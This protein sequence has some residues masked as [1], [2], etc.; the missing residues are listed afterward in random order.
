MEETWATTQKSQVFMRSRVR[1]HTRALSYISDKT[2]L[3]LWLLIIC[4]V[5][6]FLSQA[7]WSNFLLTMWPL[8]NVKIVKLLIQ[9]LPKFQIWLQIQKWTWN[10]M[11]LGFFNKTLK[12]GIIL[13]QWDW[14]KIWQRKRMIQSWDLIQHCIKLLK[15]NKIRTI[16][17]IHFKRS[18][19]SRINGLIQI[20]SMG[21]PR[22]WYIDLI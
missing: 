11:T 8:I 5:R 17:L 20:K 18:C 6:T 10:M 2:S 4:Q 3:L 16:L 15:T 13:E 7:W 1:H 22:I 12:A 21:I 14:W 19:N 9:H